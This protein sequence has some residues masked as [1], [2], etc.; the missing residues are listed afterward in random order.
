MGRFSR[1]LPPLILV[2]AF[3]FD[4]AQAQKTGLPTVTLAPGQG[5]SFEQIHYTF[6]KAPLPNSDSVLVTADPQRLFEATGIRR[7]YVNIDCDAG[8]IVRNLLVDLSDGYR[9]STRAW[10]GTDRPL[11]ITLFNASVVYSDQP[12]LDVAPEQRTVFPVTPINFNARGAGD[13]EPTAPPGRHVAEQNF[14]VDGQNFS[15]VLPNL[16]NV[17]AAANQCFPA[18]VANSL[19]YL[20]DRYGINVPDDHVPGLRG[21]DSLVGL[22]DLNSNRQAPSRLEGRGLGFL[23]MMAGKGVYLSSSGLSD[24]L[25]H[26]HQGELAGGDLR[27]ANITSSDEGEALTFEWLCGEI[28]AGNDVELVYNFEDASGAVTG[29]HAVRVIGCG[30]QNGVPWI[31]YA[32]DISQTDQAGGGD[33]GGTIVQRSFLA[34]IDDDGKLNLE[35]YNVELKYAISESVTDAIKYGPEGPPDASP[36]GTTNAASFLTTALPGGAIA[37]AFGVFNRLFGES[38]AE[39]TPEGAEQ[40]GALPTSLAGASVAIDGV[41]AP[42]FFVGAGQ[43]NFQ[44]P[45]EIPPG[46]SSVVITVDGASSPIFSIRI[47]ENGPGLFLLPPD[48]AGPGRGVIQNQ[49]FSLNTPQNPAAPG[50]VIVVYLPGLGELDEPVPSGRPARADPLSRPVA[51]SSAS[52]GGEEAEILFLG[53]TPDFVGLGQANLRV[54][55]L[56]SGDHAVVITIGEVASNAAL[57]AVGP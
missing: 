41:P 32:H 13:E 54:P 10:A 28:K 43:I 12:L 22:L 36:D 46:E 3:L 16:S 35:A 44:I 34:D 30:R 19:Q 15:V 48:L 42:L 52:I 51:P 24:S 23:Q 55:S 1:W 20:E 5:V 38:G 8:W 31:K 29:G 47:P 56:P 27:T 40:S 6:P 57:L 49:D 4:G 26:K 7:G 39:L 9:V 33:N 14:V 17:E 2:A 37:T 45:Y 53:M 21:D 11:R 18:S 50:G 25:I